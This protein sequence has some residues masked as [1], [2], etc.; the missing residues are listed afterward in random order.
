PDA[1]LWLVIGQYSPF[2]CTGLVPTRA[3]VFYS[4]VGSGRRHVGPPGLSQSRV[5]AIQWHA[6]KE[7]SQPEKDS[8]GRRLTCGSGF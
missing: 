7:G 5:S 2:C 3:R 1:W 6:V 4:G 8:D